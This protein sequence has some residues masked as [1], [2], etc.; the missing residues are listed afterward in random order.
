MPNPGFGPFSRRTP[1]ARKKNVQVGYR[2]QQQSAAAG[3]LASQSIQKFRC[4]YGIAGPHHWRHRFKRPCCAMT[5]VHR[6]SAAGIAHHDPASRWAARDHKLE[7]TCNGM[8]LG[9]AENCPRRSRRL[10]R[11]GSS[12]IRFTQAAYSPWWY[13]QNERIRARLESISRRVNTLGADANWSIAQILPVVTQ[14]RSRR[15]RQTFAL[16]NLGRLAGAGVAT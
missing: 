4:R 10:P 3:R 11:S 12:G 7:S 5:G 6:E 13:F 1:V 15:N 8:A 14:S 9:T 16:N 2:P